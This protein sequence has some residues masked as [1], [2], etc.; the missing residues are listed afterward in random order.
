[1][2]NDL[3]GRSLGNC[4]FL[5]LD[6]LPPALRIHTDGIISGFYPQ[7]ASLYRSR[8]CCICWR[9]KH[10]HP[11]PVLQFT[12]WCPPWNST[13][14]KHHLCLCLN[15]RWKTRS[16][17]SKVIDVCSLNQETCMHVFMHI[18]TYTHIHVHKYIYT[19][20]H[21]CLCTHTYVHTHTYI[22]IHIHIY[23]FIHIH[24]HIHIHIP[25]HKHT[26]THTYSQHVNTHTHV[27]NCDTELKKNTMCE[28]TNLTSTLSS[29]L[30]CVPGRNLFTS[31]NNYK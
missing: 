22:F 14:E 11:L 3:S 4:L 27:N 30:F 16:H 20:I 12:Q 25:T 26:Y 19:Y 17:I 10:R 28:S 21:T 5:P 8:S 23:L 9:P 18:H 13:G 2:E 31:E 29:D 24:T 1:M 15:S 6:K 7:P